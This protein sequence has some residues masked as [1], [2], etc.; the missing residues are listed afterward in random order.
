LTKVV[1]IQLFSR[2]ETNGDKRGGSGLRYDRVSEQSLTPHP[3]QYRSLRR[4]W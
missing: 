2:H 1:W 4:R 3:T